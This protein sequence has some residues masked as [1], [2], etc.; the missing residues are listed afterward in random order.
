[1]AF[2][3]APLSVTF[4]ATSPKGYSLLISIR[5]D[6]FDINKI[7]EIDDELD[8]NGFAVKQEKSFGG[9]ASKTPKEIEFVPDREC[10]KCKNKLVYF[11][12][13]GKKNIKCS[14]SKWDWK[15]KATTGCNFTEWANDAP[16]SSNEPTMNDFPDKPTL[17]QINLIKKL[18]GEGRIGAD[19]SLQDL[20]K[21]K[22]RDLIASAMFS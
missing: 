12:A 8:L 15:T 7:K 3:D 6:K 14:T 1:M 22:A 21:Q 20:S 11:E 5:A 9:Y 4:T 19:I 17:P 13:K 18:Q 10:P 2:T 16:A